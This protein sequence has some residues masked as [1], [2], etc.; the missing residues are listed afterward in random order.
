LTPFEYIEVTLK[1]DWLP[2]GDSPESRTTIPPVEIDQSGDQGFSCQW[3]CVTKTTKIAQSFRGKSTFMAHIAS[4]HPEL[5]ICIETPPQLV[6]KVGGNPTK[7]RRFI[8][9][10][11]NSVLQH[12]LELEEFLFTDF[13][14]VSHSG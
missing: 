9:Q 3:G 4:E 12:Y 2:V 13:I 5:R 8:I 14:L 6:L 11:S 7:G 1:S 10:E